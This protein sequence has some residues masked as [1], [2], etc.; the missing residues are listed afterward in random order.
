MKGLY[1]KYIVTK[2][3]GKPLAEG[4]QSIVLRVDGGQYVEAC[5]EGAKAFAKAVKKANP[6]LAEDIEALLNHYELIDL[7]REIEK[8]KKPWPSYRYE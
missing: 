7:G 4:F 1:Q 6:M 2:T 5:R 3:S 8:N